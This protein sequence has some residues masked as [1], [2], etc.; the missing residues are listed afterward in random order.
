MNCKP[1]TCAPERSGVILLVVL[2]ALTFFSLLVATY[3]VFSNESRDAS[4]ALSQRSTR[5]PDVNWVMNEALMTLIRGTNDPN[6]PFF[7]E[8]LLS[9][10]YGRADGMDLQIKRLNSFAAGPQ[11]MG[12]GFVRFPVAT[13]ASTG[14]NRPAVEA[15]DDVYAGTLITFTQGPLQNQ[16]YRV[17]RSVFQPTTAGIPE[18]DDI[19]IEIG[20]GVL[21]ST[22]PTANAVNSL[23]YDDPSD[24]TIAGNG[25]TLRLNG[26]PRNS[27]GIGFETATNNISASTHTYAAPNPPLAQPRDPFAAYNAT[28]NPAAG[29]NFPAALQPNH[30][31]RNVD[32]SMTPGDFDEAYDAADFNNWFLSHRRSDGSIIP[33]FHRPAVLNY[34]LN[35]TADWSAAS[36][37][38]YNNLM[39]SFARATFRPL[40]IG[41][42]SSRP[43]ASRSTNDSPAAAPSLPSVRHCQSPGEP[44]YWINWPRR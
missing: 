31:G 9:D 14:V 40:P 29:H 33:S 36:T 15:I 30:L 4:F 41:R 22:T 2:G 38:D 28:S 26:T 21:G 44:D 13:S 25:F 1:D 10:Y 34:I 11:F 20:E 16:T 6:N 3:L 43:A 24:L 27:R 42:D 18:Y 39:V 37:A 8:D 17:L 19:Y 7:G 32:K 23:F 35:E 12:G 5:A